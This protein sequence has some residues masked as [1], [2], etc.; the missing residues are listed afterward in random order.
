MD[1]THSL[2]FSAGEQNEGPLTAK[3]GHSKLSLSV[4]A[5]ANGVA[6]KRSCNVG[7]VAAYSWPAADNFITAYLIV[8]KIMS[9]S[10]P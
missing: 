10:F 5:N 1:A 8:E 9:A 4:T 3:S 2:N 7:L 6:E